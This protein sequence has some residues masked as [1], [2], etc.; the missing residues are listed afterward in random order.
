ML[1]LLSTFALAQLKGSGKTIT[2]S[3]DYQNFDKVLFNDLDGK[4]EVE[5]GKPYSIS[6]TIDDNLLNLLTVSE[7]SKNKTLAVSLKGNN[8][9]K[10][11]IEDTKIKVKISMPFLMEVSN[12]GNSRLTV[13]N[14]N[15]KFFKSNNPV[16]GSTTL[17]GIV[18]ALEI[19]CSGNG[20][21]NAKQLL[22]KNAKIKATGNGNA[23][24]NVT[25][26][27]TVKT[28]GNCTVVNTGNAKFDSESSSSGNS[29][30]V[31]N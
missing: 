18:D 5:V 21:L 17:S 19:F 28:S 11:Y 22:V 9:N 6:I 2:K 30:F 13:T 14:I 4:I 20:V 31:N 7:N 25:E 12:N 3:Y 27:I 29:R 24:I 8:N 16:N 10:L 15:S 1:M 26:F 23:Y